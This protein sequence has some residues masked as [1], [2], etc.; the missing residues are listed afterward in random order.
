MWDVAPVLRYHSAALD[1]GR[2]TLV[3]F[4]ATLRALVPKLEEEPPESTG[5][6]G[7]GHRLLWL[8]RGEV[9]G[10]VPKRQPLA[11]GRA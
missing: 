11:H 10:I 2:G 5:Q 9:G 7:H 1:G 4:R 3:E 6:M 8:K